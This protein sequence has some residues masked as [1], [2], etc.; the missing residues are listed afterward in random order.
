MISKTKIIT[1]MLLSITITLITILIE[2]NQL[3]STLEYWKNII[4]AG[5]NG[6]IP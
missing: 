4:S 1:L 6:I 3:Y 2:F 5:L